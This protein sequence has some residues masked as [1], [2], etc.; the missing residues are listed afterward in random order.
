MVMRATRSLFAGIL[1]TVL[2]ATPLTAATPGAEALKIDQAVTL[3]GTLA[4]PFWQS[5]K[6]FGG[7]HV[8]DRGDTGKVANDTVFRL[9]YDNTWLYVGVECGNP[10]Q[11]YVLAPSVGDHDGPVHTDESVELFLTSDDRGK[12]YYHFKLSCFNVRAEQR[13]LDGAR[14]LETWNLPW[15]SSTAV[16]E[17]GWTAEAAVPLY[18]FLEHGDLDHVR[19]N[20]ARNQ[21]RP[22]VDA[23]NVITHEAMGHSIWRAVVRS[24]HETEVFGALAPLRPGKLQVP[25][26][27]S[28]ENVAVKPYFTKNGANFYHVDVTL[29]GATPIPGEVDVVV[30]DRPVTGGR[31]TTLRARVSVNGLAVRDVPFDVP[32]PLPS[33]RSIAVEV[34]SVVTGETLQATTIQNPACLQVMAAYLDR[35]YYTSE[36][37]AVAVAETGMPAASL[38]GMNVAVEIDGKAVGSAPAAS[39][40]YVRFPIRGLAVGVHPVA[41]ALRRQAGA[42][43]GAVATE[44]VKRAPNPGR[45][46]KIDQV[47]RVVLKDDAPLFPLGL[48]MSGIKP[49]DEADFKAIADAGCNTFVQWYKSM[50]ASDADLFLDSAKRHGLYGMTMLETGWPGPGSTALELPRQLLNAEELKVLTGVGRGGSLGM[51]GFLMGPGARRHST[52]TKTALFREYC[53]KNLPVTEQVLRSVMNADNL[54]GYTSFDEPFDSRLFDMTQSLDAIYRRTQRTDGY[55]PTWVLYSSHIPAGAEYVTCCDI[56]VTDPYWVPAGPRGRET[57]NYVSKTV[58]R[59]EQRAAEFRKVVWIV[60]VGWHWSGIRRGK[61][62]LTAAEQRCQ[63]ALAI[64]HGARGLFWFAYPM[65]TVAWENLKQSIAMVKAIGP[66]AVQPQ[67]RQETV[68]VRATESEPEYRKAPFLPEKDEFP[69][70]QGR[71]F[72]DPAGGLVLLAANSRYYPV[73]ATFTVAGLAARVERLFGQAAL[74]VEDGVFTEPLEPFAVRAYRLGSALEEPVNMTIASLRPAHLPP[75]EASAPNNCRPGRKNVFP[76]PSFEEDTVTGLPDYYI[77]GS[78][79]RKGGAAK[80]GGKCLKLTNNTGKAY[81]LLSWYCGPRHDR[82][83]A[84][85]WSFWARGAEGGEK[86]WVADTAEGVDWDKEAIRTFYLTTE[87]QRYEKSVTVAARAAPR[88]FEIRL[89]CQGQAWLDGLQLEQGY[90]PTAFEE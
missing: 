26:L 52:P 81:A 20:L 44:L 86:I 51:R 73:T 45:E 78:I 85:T 41:I 58:H 30:T 79:D 49:E 59:N 33:E 37:E 9:A 6:R 56:L 66:L 50:P 67:V 71:I 60:N 3:D 12:V 90:K 46:V 15:R 8:W 17:T 1:A 53:D 32:A 39:T 19:L 23:S 74:P 82:D 48:I 31:G 70:V 65:P 24:F 29:K 18:L 57:P 72:R 75:P 42:P 87:W 36:P 55:H 69:D 47:N 11:N 76:N 80:F 64:I 34:C 40:T 22:H 88:V 27:V 2:A 10:L 35:N 38:I 5:A 4:E 68:H 28:L 89:W 43:F 63:N 84:Y 83:T 16:T 54:L 7:F 25:F 13:F 77:G 14:E 61:R 62:V 21:R